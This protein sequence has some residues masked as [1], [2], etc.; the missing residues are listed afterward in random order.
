LEAVESRARKTIDDKRQSAPNPAA[1]LS[2]AEIRVVLRKN[3]RFVVRTVIIGIVI[4]TAFAFLIPN[5]YTSNAQ[6][7]PPDPQ[8]FNN[9]NSSFLSALT[10]RGLLGVGI[11]A[12]GLMNQRTPGGTAIGILHSPRVLDAII[13]QFDLRKV[14]H[15]RF[16]YDA[17]KK[18]L[19]HSI[20]AEDTKSGIITISVTD[21]DRDRAQGIAQLYVE[22][23]NE[24]VNSLSTSSARRERIF[25]E[26]RLKSIKNDLDANTRALSQFSSRNSMI[27]VQ[28]QGEATVDAAGKLQAELITAQS[29]LS[30]LRAVYANDNVRVLEARSRIKEL[31]RQL[32]DITGRVQAADATTKTGEGMPSLRMLP[33]L[34]FTYYDLYRKVTIDETLYESLSKEYEL[35][36]VREAEEIPQIVVLDPAS[37]PEKKSF[38]PRLLIILVGAVLSFAGALVWGLM[39]ER[40]YVPRGLFNS[41]GKRF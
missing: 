28:K 15:C 2:I 9:S 30:A 14:Y 6:L 10:G 19:K 20:F 16:Y 21:H 34:G 13:S 38:P 25:L 26:G 41:T 17:R 32:Q 29:E 27:D 11:G 12:G 18:L 22:E 4:A 7:M 39:R 5:E 3:L 36:K 37:L 35:A 24:L 1:I 33:L 40:K 31:Q 23:L 8:T